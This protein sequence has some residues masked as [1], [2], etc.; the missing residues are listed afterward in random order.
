MSNIVGLSGGLGT[1]RNPVIVRYTIATANTEEE[2]ILPTGTKAFRIHNVG[3]RNVLLAYSTGEI[4]GGNYI[5]LPPY[6]PWSN[7]AIISQS[8]LS[9]FIQSTGTET[10]ELEIWR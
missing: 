8:T 10:V 4:A 2:I 9:L 5:T 1:V 7:P 6:Y 3:V